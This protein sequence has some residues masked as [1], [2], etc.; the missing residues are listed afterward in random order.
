MSRKKRSDRGSRCVARY[1]CDAEYYD[2]CNYHEPIAE[3]DE[4]C[5]YRYGG[6]VDED[7]QEYAFCSCSK[8][9]KHPHFIEA[10]TKL[11]KANEKV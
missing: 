4:R 3:K 1:R 9:Q 10:F 7:G 5:R 8:A 11:G 6:V 2:D